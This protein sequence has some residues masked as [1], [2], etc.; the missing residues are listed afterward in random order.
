M[1][2]SARSRRVALALGAVGMLAGSA[3]ATS[4]SSVSA[5]DAKDADKIT[6]DVKIIAEQFGW[7]VGATAEHMA[8]QADFGQLID[9]A[10]NKF[11][12]NFAGASF[13]EKPGGVSQ[14]MVAG[15]APGSLVQLVEKSGMKIELVE[16]LKFT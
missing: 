14:I 13:A 4:G 9:V 7:D 15:Q 5:R 2:I 11:A 10:A 16:G 8:A 6:T 12:R 3:I 1:T